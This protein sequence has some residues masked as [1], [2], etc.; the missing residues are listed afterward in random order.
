M[1]S[2]RRPLDGLNCTLSTR[3]SDLRSVRENDMPTTT[4]AFRGRHPA[5]LRI[6]HPPKFT[7]ARSAAARLPN[8]SSLGT[9]VS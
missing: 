2:D 4:V 9:L 6:D 5:K 7:V 8:G 3:C 1:V